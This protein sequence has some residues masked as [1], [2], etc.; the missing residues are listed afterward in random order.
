MMRGIGVSCEN[1]QLQDQVVEN[2]SFSK[3]DID[4]LTSYQDSPPISTILAI[5]W[6]QIMQELRSD[7]KIKES[8]SKEINSTYPTRETNMECK[9]RIKQ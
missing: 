1:N 9:S 6:M 3:E 2:A 5:R 4:S 8:K 7:D